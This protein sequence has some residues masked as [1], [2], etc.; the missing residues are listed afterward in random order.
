MQVTELFESPLRLDRYLMS[1]LVLMENVRI[2][3][4]HIKNRL[5]FII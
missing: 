4:K 2:S 3:D 1:A 5:N